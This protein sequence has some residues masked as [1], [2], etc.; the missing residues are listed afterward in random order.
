MNADLRDYAWIIIHIIIIM[1]YT[2]KASF[3]AKAAPSCLV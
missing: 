1:D 2:V 3:K